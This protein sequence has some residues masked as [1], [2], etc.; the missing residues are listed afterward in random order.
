MWNFP[1][2]PWF[3]SGCLIWVF[4]VFLIEW[5]GL[6]Y[7]W[8]FIVLFPPVSLL[9]GLFISIYKLSSLGSLVQ[10]LITTQAMDCRSPGSGSAEK[11]LREKD[12][13]KFCGMRISNA[14][15]CTYI[16]T[17]HYITLHYNHNY[18]TLH[19]ITIHTY[20]HIYIHR[21]IYIYMHYI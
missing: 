1:T 12:R 11:A 17:L 10:G 4:I 5:Q 2:E 9:K 7:L 6:Q 21:Y 18:I 20:I 14:S 13:N 15:L 3:L 16:H 8:V 19:Y